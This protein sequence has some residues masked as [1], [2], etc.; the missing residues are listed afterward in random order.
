[1]AACLW[2]WQKRKWTPGQ[3]GKNRIDILKKLSESL[4]RKQVQDKS[5]IDKEYFEFD[6]QNLF[7]KLKHADKNNHSWCR[8]NLYIIIFNL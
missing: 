6:S 1:M 8:I 4:F 5:N 2:K 3:K 7:Q